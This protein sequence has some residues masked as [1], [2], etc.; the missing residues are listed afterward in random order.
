V[1]AYCT[2]QDAL[3]W[4]SAGS[5]TDQQHLLASVVIATDTLV[6]NGHNLVTGDPF[7]I[8]LQ[9]GDDLPTPLAEAT[10]YYAIVLTPTTFQAALSEVDALAGTEIN[11]TATGTSVAAI[12][13]IPWTR[14]IERVSGELDELMIGSAMPL[15]PA[16]S[17]DDVPSIVRNYA[18]LMA[19]SRA[20][21]FTG[22]ADDSLDA[23]IERAQ[24]RLDV[25]ASGKP[26]RADAPTATNHAVSGTGAD[27]R[28]WTVT[29]G[30]IP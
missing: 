2:T 20:A 24:K 8:R 23:E 17:I 21:L 25:Y 29:G 16:M 13:R 14:I 27:P 4:L 11:I 19:I 6:L 1:S 9:V 15:D 22:Q 26:I 30:T 12:L 7:E 18:S 28:G 10:E 5:V 3:S